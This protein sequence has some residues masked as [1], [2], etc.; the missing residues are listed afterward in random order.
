MAR[1]PFIDP[2]PEFAARIRGRRR[3]KV[4][5]VYRALSHSP[6]LAESWFEHINRIRWET[7]LTG[8][9]R[10]II[11]VRMAF[12][13]RSAYVMRQHVPTLA[14]AE[15]VTADTCRALGDWRDSPLFDAGE[16]AALAY[17]DAMTANTSVSD[18]VF[19]Q[20]KSHYS[21]RQIVELTLLIGAYNSH[22]R[23][24]EALKVDLETGPRQ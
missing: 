6:P 5:N 3:G 12:S 14:E 2:E 9:L 17:A 1:V 11:I 21:D 18:E 7:Q 23:V 4:I 20:L 16:R 8:R 13:T 24:L 19:D 10:E 15:G 22:I